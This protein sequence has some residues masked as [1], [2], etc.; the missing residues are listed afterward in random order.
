MRVGAVCVFTV[1][2]EPKRE[3]LRHGRAVAAWVGLLYRYKSRLA[4]SRLGGC[5]S[6]VSC[7]RSLRPS[8]C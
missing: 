8:L 7:V 2:D 1:Y 3:E 5:G 6:A 4:S